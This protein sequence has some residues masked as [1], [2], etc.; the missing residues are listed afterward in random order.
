[1]PL[2]RRLPVIGVTLRGGDH[3]VP[4]DLQSVLDAVVERGSYDLDADYSRPPV[5]PLSPTDA[6]WA[7]TLTFAKTSP[8][9][10]RPACGARDHRDAPRKRGG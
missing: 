8:P 10:S 7:R 4:L 6:Q 5:P 2:R 1:M 9:F 3:D